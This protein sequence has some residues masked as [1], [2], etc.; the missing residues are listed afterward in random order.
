MEKENIPYII[1]IFIVIL[2]VIII[3]YYLYLFISQMTIINDATDFYFAMQ[4]YGLL[5]FPMFIGAGVICFIRR[6]IEE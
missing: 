3:E 4:N 5:L 1:A 6:L 2:L